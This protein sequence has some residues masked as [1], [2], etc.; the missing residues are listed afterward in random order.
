[1]PDSSDVVRGV[2]GALAAAVI[3]GVIWGVIVW[4]THYEIAFAAIGVGWLVGRGMAIATGHKRARQL[5]VIAVLAS[6]LGI[7]IGKYMTLYFVLKDQY[8]GV[9]LF[10][11]RIIDLIRN[12]PGTVF[13]LIDILFFVI[14]VVYAARQLAPTTSKFQRDGV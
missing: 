12:D 11:S 13:S 10:D 2:A 1:V 4:Q 3:A 14:A 8:D 5:Q 6:V 7:M 9:K